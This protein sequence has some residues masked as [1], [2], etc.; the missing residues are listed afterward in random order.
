[1]FKCLEIS[2]STYY[3]EAASPCDETKL[4]QEILSILHDN[5]DVYGSRKIKRVLNQSGKTVSR[6]KIGLIMKKALCF[7][8]P[9]V[10][11]YEGMSL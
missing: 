4:D 10:S 3:Y 2:R 5:R 8:Y 9:T 7:S 1:M 11:Q 6:R